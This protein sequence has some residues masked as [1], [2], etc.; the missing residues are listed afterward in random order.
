VPGSL[1]F[2]GYDSS[3]VQAANITTI[4]GPD[5]SRDLTLGLQSI[6][7]SISGQQH[8]LLPSPIFTF[9]DSAVPHIWLP[10]S[11][12]TEFEHAFGLAYNTALDL[13]L[14]NDTLHA[15]LLA[16][17]ASISFQIGNTTTSGETIDI[18][19]PYAALDLWVD[20]PIVTNKTR[21]F[22][23]KRAD[24][25][26][27]YTL[28]RTFLQEAYLTVDYERSK[29]T[30]SQVR[31]DQNAN[32]QIVAIPSVNSSSS[33]STASSTSKPSHSSLSTGAIVGIAIGAIVIVVLIIAGIFLA[34]KRS[35][36]KRNAAEEV[37]FPPG[38]KDGNV[39]GF[40]KAELDAQGTA[41]PGV[42]IGGTE[43]AKYE[44]IAAVQ[45]AKTAAEPE[46]IYEMHGEGVAAHEMD[47]P[48]GLAD[49]P[50]EV[51]S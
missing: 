51:S 30:V 39:D 43:A 40:G 7:T 34:I 46:P 3:K 44:M 38:N 15:A 48:V 47:T 49:R 50:H 8:N 20:Y 5:I 31:W 22:P 17:N 14:V 16:Q 41:S 23:L 42:E 4:F 19:L 45:V 32:Q 18:T 35:R 9:I 21:Y 28:G 12:C 27:Q 11:S 6:S 26:T 25:D 29:F 2:G 13:Y 37:V 24:N 36:D 1:I 33:N 10:I